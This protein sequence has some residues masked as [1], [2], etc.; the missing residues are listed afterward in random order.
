MFLF[1]F[2]SG[3]EFYPAITF[4][5]IFSLNVA[6]YFLYKYKKPVTL[7]IN[8]T[9]L[10]INY[11]FLIKRNLEDLTGI[12]LNGITKKMECSFRHSSGI[13]INYSDYIKEDIEKAIDEMIRMSKQE[14][15]LSINLRR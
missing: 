7:A 14:V 6:G 3:D 13:I 9:E 8:N 12:K 10:V 15:D 5:L 2:R 4:G 1:F 11:S